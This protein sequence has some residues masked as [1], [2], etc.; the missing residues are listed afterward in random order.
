MRERST[1]WSLNVTRQCYSSRTHLCV[2]C[3]H[4]VH[5]HL[6]IVT[7][8]TIWASPIIR[9]NRFSPGNYGLIEPSMISLSVCVCMCARVFVSVNIDLWANNFGT[10]YPTKLKF[11]SHLGKAIMQIQTLT[12]QLKLFL[13]TH[14]GRRYG[15]KWHFCQYFCNNLKTKKGAFLIF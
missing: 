8:Y 13:V 1:P 10:V 9:H 4:V 3:E 7:V 11:C 5:L 12:T 15:S 14:Q 2:F 6:C